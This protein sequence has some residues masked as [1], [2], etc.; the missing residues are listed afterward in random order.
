MSEEDGYEGRLAGE[1]VKS[2]TTTVKVGLR[3]YKGREFAEAREWVADG[4]YNGPT[5]KGITISKGQAKEIGKL[6]LMVGDFK[7]DE[8]EN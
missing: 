2:D 7:D 4:K 3:K 6:F 5:P 8:S 1:V